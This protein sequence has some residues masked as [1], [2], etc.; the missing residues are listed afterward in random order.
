MRDPNTSRERRDQLR[1]A[2]T[3]TGGLRREL[4]ERIS[5]ILSAESIMT[6]YYMTEH[7][8]SVL[9]QHAI[10]AVNCFFEILSEADCLIVPKEYMKPFK[11]PN[12][13]EEDWDE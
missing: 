11:K 5:N 1:E 4:E 13:D 7:D 8:K 9:H 2:I 3:L 6:G 12:D 10:L